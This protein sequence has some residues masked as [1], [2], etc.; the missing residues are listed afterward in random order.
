MRRAYAILKLL[1][2]GALAFSMYRCDAKLKE[3][4]EPPEYHVR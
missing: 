4:Y 2:L 3:K 1:F